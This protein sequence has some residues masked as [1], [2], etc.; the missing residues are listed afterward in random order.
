MPRCHGLTTMAAQILTAFF[1]T[2]TL[3][4]QSREP[5][6]WLLEMQ[7]IPFALRGG[8][9]PSTE[10]QAPANLGKDCCLGVMSSVATRHLP[11]QCAKFL[12]LFPLLATTVGL[13]VRSTFV[14]PTGTSGRLLLTLMVPMRTAWA[15][16]A[17]TSPLSTATIRCTALLSVASRNRCQKAITSKTLPSGSVFFYCFFWAFAL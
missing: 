3:L 7:K 14:G 1:T 6:L 2:G 12:C 11:V 13:M 5:L 17:R 9:Y 10:T 8:N 15:S 16:T 4:R